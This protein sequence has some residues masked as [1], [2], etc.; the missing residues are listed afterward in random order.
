[1]NWD[2]RLQTAV[3]DLE[4]ENIEMKGHLWYLNNPIYGLAGGFITARP[5]ARKRC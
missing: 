3:S 5:A 2:P 1:M 4:V